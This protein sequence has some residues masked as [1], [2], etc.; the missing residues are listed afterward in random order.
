MTS[1]PFGSLISKVLHQFGFISMTFCPLTFADERRNSKGFPLCSGLPLEGSGAVF[2]SGRCRVCVCA[3]T[4]TSSRR[5]GLHPSPVLHRY[6]ASIPWSALKKQQRPDSPNPADTK[7]R[8][9]SSCHIIKASRQKDRPFD[10]L[11]PGVPFPSK[12]TRCRLLRPSC[13]I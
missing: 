3:S 5:A 2:G 12:S 13:T 8:P 11:L 10:D 7:G 4:Q 6:V 1:V 9:C